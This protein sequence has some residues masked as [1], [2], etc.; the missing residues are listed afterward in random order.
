MGRHSLPDAPRARATGS[1]MAPLA[2]HRRAVVFASALALLVGAGTAVATHRDWLPFAKDCEGQRVPL[3]VAASP[4]IA[5]VLRT[6]VERAQEDGVR[7]D[8]N[9]MAITIKERTGADMA[10][11]L[12]RGGKDGE[13]QV[14]LP[15]SALW[16]RRAADS[17]TPPPMETIGNVALSPVALGAVPAAAKRLGWPG[18]THTWSAVAEAA[19]AEKNPRLG[20]ADPQRSATGL[21]ALAH[22]ADSIAREGGKDTETRTTATAKQQIGRAHV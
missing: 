11:R 6:A 19:A 9:C 17:G 5:P 3:A 7:S 15:E 14:W 12:R 18:K 4:E 10:E 8:G 22:M 13:F 2:A 20:M 16:L 1:R 21:L